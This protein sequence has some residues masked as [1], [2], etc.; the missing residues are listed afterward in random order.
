[1]KTV[2][3]RNEADIYQILENYLKDDKYFSNRK[4]IGMCC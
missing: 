2:I 4:I 3:I 1:M